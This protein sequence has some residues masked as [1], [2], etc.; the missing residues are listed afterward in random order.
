MKRAIKM[1]KN[2]IDFKPKDN[3]SLTLLVGVILLGLALRLILQCGL[4]NADSYAYAN[5]AIRLN[6]SGLGT[7]LSS[8][9]NIY[10]NRISIVLPLAFSYKLF[11]L[12]E[13]TTLLLPVLYA[14]G[15]I[16]ITYF[17]GKLLF[18]DEGIS[19]LATTLVAT[20]PLDVYYATA[21]L[22]DSTIPL[23][24]SL[25]LLC[26]VL[27][28]KKD[29]PIFYLLTGFFLFCAFEA[30]ATSGIYILPLFATAWWSTKRNFWSVFLPATAFFIFIILYYTSI[31]L[32]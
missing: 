29:N 17:L 7:Y 2:R 6:D 1:A 10:E 15:T 32:S 8:I 9:A 26:F 14:V 28:Q 11:G 13:F 20:V 16:L 22:P 31:I 24:T 30:R 25:T 27:G 19:L 18:D 12:S 3:L 21:V 5:G 23:Y 4:S